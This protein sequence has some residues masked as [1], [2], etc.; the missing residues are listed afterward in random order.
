MKTISRKLFLSLTVLTF[1]GALVSFVPIR[2]TDLNNDILNYTNKYRQSKDR[3][4]LTMREDLNAIAQ[5]HS[6]DM[7]KGKVAFGHAGFDDRDAKARKLIPGMTRFAENV[8]YGASSA[9]EV[10][11]M[12]K[13]SSGHRENMLGNYKYIG[14]GTAT[15]KKGTIYFTQVFAN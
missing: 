6:S 11:T 5:K 13:K 10:V 3:S 14:I 15:D 8:A 7:A 12:W 4:A 1:F 9:K 2:E